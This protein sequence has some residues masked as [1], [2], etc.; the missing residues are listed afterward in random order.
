M[1]QQQ[2]RRTTRRTLARLTCSTALA[3]VCAL[4]TVALGQVPL[5]APTVV[6]PALA[7]RPVVEGLV[8]PIGLAFLGRDSF[9]VLEKGTGLVK[10]VRPVNGVQT[11]SVV[12]DLSVNSASERGLLGIALHPEFP[13]NRGVYLFWTESC[14][15]ADTTNLASIGLPSPS[16][17]VAVAGQPLPDAPADPLGS[18]LD[19]FTWNGTSL[20][21]D[22]N[23]LRVRSYQADPTQPLRGNH[24]GGVV[25]ASVERGKTVLYL[26]LGDQGRRGQLQNLEFGPPA[27]ALHPNFPADDQ[28]GGPAPDAAH[29]S[30][31][32]LRLDEHGRALRDNPFYDY[33]KDLIRAGQT[34]TGQTLQKV[35]AYGVRNSFGMTIDPR[36]KSV[37]YQE[38]GDDSFSELNRAVP[39]ANGGWVQVA[40]PLSRVA[41]FKAI[42]TGTAPLTAGKYIGMQQVRFPATELADTPE[43]ARERLVMLPGAVY[44]DPVFSWRYEVA[45]GGI[46]FVSSRALG[47]QYDGNLFM[48]AAVPAMQGGYLFRFRLTGN[49]RAVAVDDPRLEDRVAD[50]LE[51]H[52]FRR[53]EDAVPGVLGIVESESLLFGRDFG[54][55][56]DVQMGPNGNLYVV[57]LSR[58][59]VYE[60]YRPGKGHHHDGDDDDNDDDRDDDRD[61][62]E[63]DR[64]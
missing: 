24:N 56:P 28:Y 53:P 57:S 20:T 37:W 45:P 7:V 31:V 42:E 41:E 19:R 52:S 60:V 50:N 54:V 10:W 16:C 14:T 40:G 47:R 49:R 23:L 11:T 22:R 5:P 29:L 59:A 35:Y 4:P 63:D 48:G 1:T 32:I 58:G 55:S 13:R 17:P 25:R 3:A 21:F 26:V 2:C 61:D 9:F 33:G 64:R 43:Q 46:G 39:G 44:T 30:G 36:S 8:Q 15:G 6:D 12:L 34:A 27:S 38:N 51:K 18:R 62:D